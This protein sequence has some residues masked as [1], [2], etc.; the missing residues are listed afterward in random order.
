VSKI[1]EK[2]ITKRRE[3]NPPG[4][5]KELIGKLL[6]AESEEQFQQLLAEHPELQR[7]E[8][9][10]LPMHE[11][12]QMLE[13]NEQVSSDTHIA[14]R[15]VMI[16][17]MQPGMASVVT[18]TSEGK[19]IA[20]LF[21]IPADTLSM[22]ILVAPADLQMLI[23]QTLQVSL[24]HPEYLTEES[25]WFLDE[26][27]SSPKTS[28]EGK[29]RLIRFQKALGLCLEYGLNQEWISKIRERHNKVVKENV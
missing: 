26:M 11:A 14:E 18:E 3:I 7:Y 24:H 15:V 4:V 20:S 2:L 22:M 25:Y 16:S 28:P 10:G 8:E 29:Q 5:P 23:A 27:V 17:E 12:L 13:I 19:R 9:V 1:S 6:Y 21:E